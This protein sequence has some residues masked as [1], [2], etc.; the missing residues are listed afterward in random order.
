MVFGFLN[1]TKRCSFFISLHFCTINK[2]PNL[3]EK[4]WRSW[5]GRLTDFPWCLTNAASCCSCITADNVE[6]RAGSPSQHWAP[7]CTP[8]TTAFLHLSHSV[9]AH[10]LSTFILSPAAWDDEIH[11]STIRHPLNNNNKKIKR[12]VQIQVLRK[13]L[14]RH[15]QNVKFILKLYSIPNP[16]KWGAT[17]VL[18]FKLR[19][20]LHFSH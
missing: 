10:Q 9:Q 16:K 18:R 11:L 6:H 17:F 15:W 3:P 8:S 5:L 2:I 19:E 13:L 4:E 7:P 14:E 20:S 1:N 12:L